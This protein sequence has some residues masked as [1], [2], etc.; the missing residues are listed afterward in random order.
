VLTGY[1]PGKQRDTSHDGGTFAGAS[2]HLLRLGAVFAMRFDYVECFLGVM[3]KLVPAIY[4]LLAEA[5]ARKTWMP[6]TSA[7]VTSER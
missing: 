4:V 6:A 3:A 1:D 7:G 2:S 5:P